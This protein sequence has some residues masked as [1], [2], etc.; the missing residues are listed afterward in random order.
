MEAGWEYCSWLVSLL[1]ESLLCGEN[2]EQ[3]E[4][5]KGGKSWELKAER[6]SRNPRRQRGK[7]GQIKPPRRNKGIN[8][9]F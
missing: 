1:E 3:E 5:L 8:S 2:I 7:K 6:T 4:K 9:K